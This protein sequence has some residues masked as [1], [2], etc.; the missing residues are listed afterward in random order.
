MTKIA[1]RIIKIIQATGEHPLG[2]YYC[3]NFDEAS[4]IVR[5]LR[6]SINGPQ[7]EKIDFEIEF[8]D[9]FRFPGTSKIEQGIHSCFSELASSTIRSY[10]SD[11]EIVVALR[12]KSDPSGEKQAYAKELAEKYDFGSWLKHVENEPVGMKM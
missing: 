1:P 7:S 8:E 5:N 12:A 11:E 10:L 6:N 9:G 2:S 3:S 4:T